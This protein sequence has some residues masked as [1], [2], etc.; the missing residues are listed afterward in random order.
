MGAQRQRA[1]VLRIERL[2]QLCPQQPRRPQLGDLHEVVHAD[3]PEEREPRREPVDGEAGAKSR[4]HIFDAVGE[5]IGEF[6]VLR[7]ARLLHV[8]AG[9]RDRVEFRHPLRSEGE[10]VGDDPDRRRR[11]VDIGVAD[12]ELLEDVVLDG[13]GEFF[14]RHALLLGG[15]DVERQHRQH[16]AVHGHRH[17]HAV[18]RDAGE[19]RA[20]VVDRIDGDSG[21]ADIAAYPGMIAVIAAVGGEIEG[22]RKPLLPGGEIAPV[23]RV[24]ILG[25][26]ESG[27]LA[28]RPR[29]GHIHGGVGAA[30]IGRDAGVGVEEVEAGGIVG[31]IDRLHRNAFRGEPRFRQ[32]G[33]SRESAGG[34]RESAGGSR[35]SAGGSRESAGGSRGQAGFGEGD[36]REIRYPAHG[37]LW[38]IGTASV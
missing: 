7:R 26:G 18:E 30:Q 12:H 24:G 4:P 2:H 38:V 23:E 28:H 22:D 36:G 8:I 35:E 21:H 31:A 5:G 16:G 37:S 9:D 33:G 27:I 29:L 32:A 17:R 13:A 14:R 3:R 11:R 25:R 6:E 10:N 34:S 19:Q 15:D 1:R 20:H